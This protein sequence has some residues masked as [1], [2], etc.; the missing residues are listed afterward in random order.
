[1]ADYQTIMRALRNADAAG[2][3]A[4]ARRLAAM[5]REAQS[6]TAPVIQPED[7][8][9][10]VTGIPGGVSEPPARDKA[11]EVEQF[12]QP[13]V[14]RG[15]SAFLSGAN[16]G[17][18]GVLD[19]PVH[20]ANKA[21]SALGAEGN[22]FG[23]GIFG[24]TLEAAGSI[25]QPDPEYPTIEKIGA[26][27]GAGVGAVSG[28]GLL[29]TLLRGGSLTNVLG[30]SAPVQAVDSALAT[31]GNASAQA[32]SRPG[33]LVASEAAAGA[34][35]VA[36][37]AAGGSVGERVGGERGRQVGESLG[38]ILGGMAPSA[39]ASGVSAGTQKLMGRGADEGVSSSEVYDALRDSGI[40]TSGGLVGNRNTARIE[41]TMAN[42]PI[43]G[44]S[45]ANKQSRQ[46]RQ[47]GDAVQNVTGRIRGYS[48]DLPPDS[49]TIG[50]KIQDSVKEGTSELTSRVNALEGNLG[51]RAAKAKTAVNVQSVKDEIA[52]L[53]AK[54]TPSQ[55]AV[56]EG[57]IRDLDAM[58]DVPIDGKLHSQLTQQQTILKR[59]LSSAQKAAT[60]DPLDKA[61]K[62]KVSTLKKNLADVD[63]KIDANLGI[64]YT[65]MRAWRTE[66]GTKTQQG[67]IP[68]G[69]MKKTYSAATDAVQDFA[70]RAG[71]RKDFD[72]LMGAEAELYQRK[73]NISEGGDIPFGKKIAD[74][75]TGSDVYNATI[76]AGVQAPEKLD[77]V[78]RN[79]APEQWNEVAADTLEYMGRAKP[80]SQTTAS[81]FSPETFLTNW[82]KLSTKSKQILAGDELEALEKL[83]TAATA[84]RGRSAAGNPS[85]TAYSGMAGAMG[86]GALTAPLATAGALGS[87]LATGKLVSSEWFARQLAGTAPKL[88][89][90]LIPRIVG[91]TGRETTDEP[92]KPLEITVTPKDKRG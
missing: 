25:R 22:F 44:G 28:A 10:P 3:V 79:M 70:S 91:Q 81:E 66:I 18:A 49:H 78:R 76:R 54:S 71:M 47:F 62:A 56:L 82:N 13:G 20:I 38:S 92:R 59:N 77:I 29:S 52:Q 58:R 55:K 31:A 17:L 15:T 1:M 6:Q 2:D 51:Q 90:R 45:V 40:D 64:D 7:V 63:A 5:A 80:G 9:D 48:S 32:L 46:V 75:P 50:T 24:P 27:T 69:A 86:V 4:A 39:I 21:A 41:N 65:R 84:F 11:A 57:A 19:S 23:E 26:N 68:G 12:G 83:A 43:V 60:A 35:S 16:R 61:A 85:G 36:G 8:R 74:M 42:V 14:A 37:E 89:E 87:G 33:A 67:G 30:S 53:S 73:G 34:G 72:D 88:A